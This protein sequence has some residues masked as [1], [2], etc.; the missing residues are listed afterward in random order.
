MLT[1]LPVTGNTD[2]SANLSERIIYGKDICLS[3]EIHFPLEYANNVNKL[4]I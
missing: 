2:E 4:G 3:P 1:L